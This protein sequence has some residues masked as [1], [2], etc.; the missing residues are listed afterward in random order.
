MY[1]TCLFCH[2]ALGANEVIESFPVG[3]RLAFDAEKGR[4]W[5]VCPR[6]G[7]WNLT[8]LE[9]RWEAVEACER[10]FRGTVLRTSTDNI[11]L[12]RL[13]EGLELIRVGRPLRPELASW[14]YGTT[15]HRRRIRAWAYGA[16][17]VAAFGVT[18]FHPL[19]GG[20]VGSLL[21]TTFQLGNVYRQL[22]PVVRMS[23][24]DGTVLR[25]SATHVMST[26]FI[27]DTTP[28]GWALTVYHKGKGPAVLTGAEALSNVGL[29]LPWI[30]YEGGSPRTV[31]DAAR[32]LEEARTPGNL[33][34][35]VADHLQM[36]RRA[37]APSTVAVREMPKSQRLAL[38]IAAHEETERRAMDGELA[39]LERAWR[40]AEE[41]AEIAD[42][43]LLPANVSAFFTGRASETR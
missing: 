23:A 10:R 8:P 5:V 9:E 38:E 2:A 27:P 40:E 1:A 3:S 42:N 34:A 4:L 41:I 24:D 15:F 37:G 14:R 20:S 26:R 32:R 16:G 13:R 12:T 17:Y 29:L 35:S 28:L 33:F 21:F 6:C 25:M 43:L 19:I 22:R 18:H 7:R 31:N 39:E 36:L 30:N 11:G